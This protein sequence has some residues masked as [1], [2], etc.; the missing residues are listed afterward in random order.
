CYTRQVRAPTVLSRLAL[1]LC[2]GSRLWAPS[3]L[4]PLTSEHARGN[5][6]VFAEA[7]DEAVEGARETLSTSGIRPEEGNLAVALGEPGP[8]ESYQPHRL[9]KRHP[10]EQRRHCLVDA[11]PVVRRIVGAAPRDRR[12]VRKAQ[13]ERHGP[14]CEPFC[15]ELSRHA[16]R[17]RAQRRS[18]AFDIR[19]ITP[20][21]LLRAHGLGDGEGLDRPIVESAR[22]GGEVRGALAEARLEIG[23][24]H[25][26]EL[27]DRAN[28]HRLE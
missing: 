2:L 25:G 22:Q 7:V 11:E 19:M 27:A 23:R 1:V 26:G 13:L 15:P 3:P 9:T 18:E 6:R 5:D 14:A 12:E 17:P 8:G 10:S 28:A 16:F 21:R 24:R 4:P 20:E